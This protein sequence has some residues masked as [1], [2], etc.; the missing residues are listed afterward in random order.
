MRALWAI[1]LT[2]AAQPAA[3]DLVLHQPVDCVLGETC[4]IQNYVDHNP[5][6]GVSDF[7]C[8]GLSY[9]GHKGTDFALPTQLEMHNGVDVLAA[10]PG[11]VRA[12]RDTMTDQLY[13]PENSASIAGQECGNGVLIAHADGWETQYCHMRLGSVVVKSGDRVE[14]GDV[15]GE[16]GLSGKTQ[17]PHLHLSVRQDGRVVD[18]FAPD[19]ATDCAVPQQELWDQDITYVPGGLTSAGFAEGIPGY[20]AV[21]AGTATRT[22][23]P[24]DAN[25]LVIFAL[26]FGSQQGDVI[27]MEIHGPEGEV[28]SQEIVLEKAQAQVYRA[29]GRR[30]TSAQWPAGTYR[31]EVA[32]LRDGAEISRKTVSVDIR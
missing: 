29:T 32:M 10:A 23:L 12:V 8:G 3:S 18:P 1:V 15:L 7:T 19:G 22:T 2:L 14:T 5:G 13:T 26:A 9:D 30:L 31:G 16:I 25:A 17:F 21:L 27:Y 20:D 6:P 11:I 24:T 4:H 28:L